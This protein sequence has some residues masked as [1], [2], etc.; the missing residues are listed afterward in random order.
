MAHKISLY[1]VALWKDNFYQ[2]Y[3]DF[4]HLVYM[5]MFD[6]NGKD[7]VPGEYKKLTQYHDF[8]YAHYRKD[9]TELKKQVIDPESFEALRIGVTKIAEKIKEEL[10]LEQYLY[11]LSLSAQYFPITPACTSLQPAISFT[12]TNSSVHKEALLFM[13]RS[14]SPH[15]TAATSAE[16]IYSARFTSKGQI[17]SRC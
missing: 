12:D 3:I 1:Q 9:A 8:W 14:D 15:T 17:K 4:I 5:R 6:V 10:P 16:K 7:Y 2:R 11:D 13:Q